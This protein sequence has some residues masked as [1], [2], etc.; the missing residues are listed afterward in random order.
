MNTKANGKRMEVGKIPPD[1]LERIVFNR[2]GAPRSEIRVRPGIGED[3][4]VIDLGNELLIATSDPITGARERAGW[5][6]VK[7]ALNDIGASGGEPLCILVT[8][9]LAEGSTQEDLKAIMDDIHEACLEENVAVAGGHSEVTPGIPE[10]LIV[11]T[12]LGKASGR[13]FL[14]SRGAAPGEDIVVTKWAGMEGTSI[15]VR[16]FLSVFS[17]VLEE[18]EV[19]EALDLLK[20]V[21]VTRDGRVAASVGAS[22]AHDATEGG[23]LGAIYEICCASSVGASVWADEIPVLPVTLKVSEFAGIDPLKL[24]SSGCLVVTGADGNRISEGFAQMGINAKVVGK[25]T[26]GKTELIRK[27]KRLPLEAPASD[28]LW[29][30]RRYLLTL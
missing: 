11:V 2:T 24:V 9:L 14:T 13:R 12:A 25:I 8:L 4:A 6:A 15:L 28:E 22:A 16:D 29:R 17:K 30:A 1:L 21:S 23:V 26:S 18:Q 5:L 20:M 27:G 19:K 3:A 10:T 7:V